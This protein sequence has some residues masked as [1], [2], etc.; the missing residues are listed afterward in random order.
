V[1]VPER[2]VDEIDFF[3]LK[4]GDILLFSC[5]R[6]I[7]RGRWFYARTASASVADLCYHVI[8]RGNAQNVVFHKASDYQVFVKLIS[9]ACDRTWWLRLV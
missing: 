9:L 3:H 2:R 1:A 6:A 4:K 7:D 5:L 8:N